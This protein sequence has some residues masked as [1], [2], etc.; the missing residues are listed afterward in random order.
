[1][2]MTANS[3]AQSI[4]EVEAAQFTVEGYEYAVLGHHKDYI[5]H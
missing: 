1:M 3:T 5:E 2:S 4:R